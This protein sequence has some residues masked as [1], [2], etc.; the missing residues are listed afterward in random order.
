MREFCGCVSANGAG[1]RECHAFV[2]RL[3]AFRRSSRAFRYARAAYDPFA[4]MDP[5]PPTSTASRE[6]ASST[7]EY[8]GLS[9]L[10]ALLVTGAIAAL[11]ATLGDRLVSAIA[12]RLLDAIGTFS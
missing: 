12:Q 2:T 11:D 8:V 1:R 4:Q 10:S 3:R 6:R 7:V 9:A 5:P